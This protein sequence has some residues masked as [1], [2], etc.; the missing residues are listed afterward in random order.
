MSHETINHA[1]KELINVSLCANPSH[2]EAVDPVVVGKTKAEQFYRNDE[3]GNFWWS[4]SLLNFIKGSLVVP[5]LLHGD[6]AFAGQG[7]VYE[8]LHLSHLP[9]YSVGGAIHLVCN[10]QIGFTTDPR[11]S[12]STTSV[13]EFLNFEK[14]IDKD[15]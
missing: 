12:R 9:F 2:L 13:L 8:T 3:D 4:L 6:A 15:I 5:I 14:I 1:S 7:V 11:H 10:N